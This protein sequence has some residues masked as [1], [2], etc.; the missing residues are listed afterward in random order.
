ML[1]GKGRK[2]IFLKTK[3]YPVDMLNKT[4]VNLPFNREK[5][6]FFMFKGKEG[7]TGVKGDRLNRHTCY[8]FFK[9]TKGGEDE[10]YLL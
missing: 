3:Y 5:N 7:F 10:M 2:M 4:I 9:I 6:L 8:K 1:Y